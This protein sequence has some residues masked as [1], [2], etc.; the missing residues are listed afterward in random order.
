MRPGAASIPQFHL[1]VI[2]APQLQKEICEQGWMIIPD[3]VRD[4]RPAM[5]S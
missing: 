5:M 4:R 1:S 3:Q 2:I